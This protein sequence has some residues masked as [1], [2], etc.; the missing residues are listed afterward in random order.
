MSSVARSQHREAS[1]LWWRAQ[2][3]QEPV[4]AIGSRGCGADGRGEAGVTPHWQGSCENAEALLKSPYD[5]LL[6]M[7]ISDFRNYPS[8]TISNNRFKKAR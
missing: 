3:A 4:G 6:I 5:V 8:N 7:D 1:L 2:G